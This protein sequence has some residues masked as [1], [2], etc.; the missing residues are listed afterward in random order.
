MLVLFVEF[1]LLQTDDILQTLMCK[2]ANT[3]PLILTFG[4]IIGT[5]LPYSKQQNSPKH[6]NKPSWWLH[7]EHRGREKSMMMVMVVVVMMMV[8]ECNLKMMHSAANITGTN[9]KMNSS[10]RMATLAKQ[11]SLNRASHTHTTPPTLIS[12]LY[13]TKSQLLVRR[14]GPNCTIDLANDLLNSVS[15]R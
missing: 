7:Y 14:F 3:L 13:F 9:K 1:V 15:F 12:A 10:E 4:F 11:Q 5:S 2:D 8:M 6:S